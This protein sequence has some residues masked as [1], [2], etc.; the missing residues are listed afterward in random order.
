MLRR[1][2]SVRPDPWMPR[3]MTIESGSPQHLQHPN[4]QE[5]PPSPQTNPV[6]EPAAAADAPAAVEKSA[7]QPEAEPATEHCTDATA[8][9]TSEA[10]PIP[11]EAQATSTKPE[12]PGA[13]KPADL[14]PAE[15]GALLAQ[16]FPALFAAGRA[17]PIKLRV[18]A[19][20]QQRAPG[21]FS[22]KSLS[23][24]LH[25]HTTSTPY[26]KALL[27]SPHRF[28]L[29]GQPAG[30][31]ADEHRAAATAEL[32]RRQAIV[33]ARRAAERE[34]QNAARR[35]A[36]R[37]APTAA[38]DATAQPTAPGQDPH[39]APDPRHPP[40]RGPGGARQDVRP[41]RPPGQP[42]RQPRPEGRR[43]DRRPPKAAPETARPPRPAAIEP[44][45]TAE[46]AA[47]LS[48]EQAAELEARRGRAAVLRAFET[49]TLTRANFCALKGMNDA[50]LE[51]ILVQARAERGQRPR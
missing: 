23:I 39:S 46:P 48:P 41:Q 15:C 33:Q 50:A 25:R 6:V 13:P 3:A 42:P 20:I 24:F 18:Q 2:S 10:V 5:T 38:A 47:P 7:A 31:V 32:E 44:A 28:D 40:R 30:E 29:D 34:A 43:E 35:N 4:M 9:A 36:Q 51:A 49:T 27:A 45:P 16:H 21:V 19:D 17:L 26:I 37:A 11:E 12:D 22:R 14:P 8:E 1:R